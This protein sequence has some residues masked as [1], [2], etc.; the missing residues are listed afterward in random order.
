MRW[1]VEGGPIALVMVAGLPVGLLV[2]LAV[3]GALLA[4]RRV[5]PLV[6]V[7]LLLVP[8]LLGLVS[9]GIAAHGVA[10]ATAQVAPDLRMAV[11]AAR[12]SQHLS[13]GLIPAVVL[14]LPIL[15][16]LLL[17]AVAGVLRGPRRIA[18]PLLALGLTVPL[19]LLP[20]G[21][22][23]LAEGVLS[24]G[25]LRAAVYALAGTLVALGLAGKDRGNSAPCA[26]ATGALLLPL[27]VGPGELAVVSG[28]LAQVFDAMAY[29]SPESR[30]ALLHRGME[31]ID[32][33][34]VWAWITLAVSWGFV[35]LGLVGG[36]D[37][38]AR[39]AA[40][41]VAAA[42]AVGLPALAL[43]LHAGSLL[44]QAPV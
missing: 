24:L 42:L 38:G 6:P 1:L 27:L 43:G 18:L 8:V 36:M 22:A 37:R 26:G 13:A 39:G 41:L 10:E 4:N 9:G 34:V 25:L 3:G 16:A 20:L 35:G 12:V 32:G 11:Y 23:V 44:L 19:A 21:G 17:T 5:P 28:G 40:L 33:Q 14:A 15:L 31:V 29:I 2:A 7:G 30:D